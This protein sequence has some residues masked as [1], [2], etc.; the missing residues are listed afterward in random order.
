MRE[1]TGP[2]EIVPGNRFARLSCALLLGSLSAFFFLLSYLVHS[3]SLVPWVPLR[4]GAALLILG[5][6]ISMLCFTAVFFV[7]WSADEIDVSTQGV[8]V[9]TG[10]RCYKCEW[11]KIDLEIADGESITSYH[12]RFSHPL[13][14][15]PF[16]FLLTKR[17]WEVISQW[18]P[19]ARTNRLC[20]SGNL[21]PCSSQRTANVIDTRQ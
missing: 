16:H 15:R 14:S 5:V 9:R 21:L 19:V 6:P 12:L 10:K 3:T 7:L 4:Y 2:P 18:R 1:G 17:Q 8:S 13:R 11:A 20:E